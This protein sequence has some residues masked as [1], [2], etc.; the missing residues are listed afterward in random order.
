M[1]K[2]TFKING[3]QYEVEIGTIEENL[4]QVSVNGT[5]FD[6]ELDRDVKP[7][8]TPKLVRPKPVPLTDGADSK[9]KTNTPAK[10]AAAGGV[11]KSP[12][13]GTIL[14]IHVKEGQEVSIG[15]K[16]MTLEAM[17]MENV[18]NSDKEGK[19]TNIKVDKGDSVME[20]DV[21]IEIGG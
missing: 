10:T 13:P 14:D 11:I 3:N 1:K 19:I 7:S 8:K 21:L 17:K 9:P 18:V 5:T 15:T 4:A 6:V 2:F 12:L 16:L 20:G